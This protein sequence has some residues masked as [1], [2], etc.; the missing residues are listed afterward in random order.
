[1]KFE[2]GDETDQNLCRVLKHEYLRCSEAYLDFIAA[3]TSLRRGDESRQIS[4]RAYARFLLHLYEFYVGCEQRARQDTSEIRWP[5]V[6]TL[7]AVSAQRA[8]RHLSTTFGAK[9]LN[10]APYNSGVT[11]PIIKLKE[12]AKAFR[13]ARNTAMGHVKHQRAKLNLSDFYQKFHRYL[14]SMHNAAA[15]MWGSIGDEFPDLGEVTA[16]SVLVKNDPNC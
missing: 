16:F 6:D 15:H 1:M 12:F 5:E 4:Y 13:R 7:R 14:L 3:A 8:F 10:A 2:S 11:E 9:T